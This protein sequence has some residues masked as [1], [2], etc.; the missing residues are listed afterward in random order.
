MAMFQRFFFLTAC[1]AAAG[2]YGADIQALR[3]ADPRN[4]SNGYHIPAENYTDQPYVVVT[5]N[6]EWV[7]VLTT[8]AGLEGQHGQHVV[9]T[10]STNQGKAWS[11]PI[12]IEPEQAPKLPGPRRC[13]RLT[14]AFTSSTCSTAMKW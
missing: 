11:T 5:S 10:V 4:I 1:L 12:D 8:G 3:A 14:A 9:S 2:V 7:C 6:G 13:S